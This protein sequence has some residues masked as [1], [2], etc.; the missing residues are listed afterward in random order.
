MFRRYILKKIINLQY[1]KSSFFFELFG[2]SGVSRLIN[3]LVHCNCS[4]ILF[5]K[6]IDGEVSLLCR[7]GYAYLNDR[8]CLKV[9]KLNA[10]T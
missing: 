1:N 4:R 9:N 2:G 8:T 3:V 5:P 7:L 10:E 6:Y